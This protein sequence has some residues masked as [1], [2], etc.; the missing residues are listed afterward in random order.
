MMLL[1]L[2]CEVP[3]NSATKRQN[4]ENKCVELKKQREREGRKTP[5][6]MVAL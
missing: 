3:D 5:V 4:T 6:E 2:I 1:F